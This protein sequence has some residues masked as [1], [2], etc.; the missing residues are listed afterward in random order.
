MLRVSP[1]QRRR[2]AEIISNLHERITEAR[3]N[4]WLGEVQGLEVSLKAANAS[5]PAS[6][7]ASNETAAP[8]PPTSECRPSVIP[9]NRRL[10]SPS[11]HWRIRKTDKS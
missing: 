2:L 4:G 8:D 6:T 3:M 1:H 7:E 11:N 10:P 5:S 9:D